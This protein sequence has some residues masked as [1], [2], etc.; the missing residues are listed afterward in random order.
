[1]NN[2]YF[3][4]RQIGKE[5]P[6]QINLIEN[7]LSGGKISKSRIDTLDD[8]EGEDI[9]T[10]S[11]LV[12]DTFEYL[13]QKFGHKFRVINF[14]KCPRVEDFSP[15][16]SLE[17]I[18]YITYFWNQRVTR[19]WNFKKTPKLLGLRFDDFT[20][21]NS[22]IDLEDA[23]SLVELGFGNKVWS[24]YKVDSLAPLATLTDLE[25]L[26][27]S[28]KKIADERIEPIAALKNLKT[29]TFPTNLFTTEQVAWLKARLPNTVESSVLNAFWTRD[30]SLNINGK[31][32]KYPYNWQKKAI[33]GFQ[34]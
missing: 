21:L 30:K 24:K 29:L 22:L 3:Y 9:L 11:G 12:Q 16:E 31:K 5:H 7:D 18:E 10:V 32:Q 26:S 15:I 28:A 4:I 34:P 13:I 1:M 23:S 33:F 8:L 25:H 14:W 2:I 27:I 17:N 6:S 19:L 20:R